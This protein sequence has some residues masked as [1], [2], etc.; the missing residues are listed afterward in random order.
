MPEVQRRAISERQKGKPLSDNAI[1][2]AR[3]A[4]LGR[5]LAEEHRR[6]ISL[7]S[8]GKP[9]TRNGA[10]HTEDT[11]RHISESNKGKHSVPMPDTAK[12]KLR[13]YWAGRPWS[14]ARRAAYERSK[15]RLVG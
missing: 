14:T 1:E 15:L 9:G 12:Q 10:K 4:N 3:Q 13:A 11:K 8:M 5:K 6:K 7:G 2:K